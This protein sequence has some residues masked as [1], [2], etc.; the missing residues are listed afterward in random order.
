MFNP[1]QIKD[2]L[3]NKNVYKCSSES[4]TYSK[5]F[6]L[7]AIRRYYDDGY[8]P[9]A[10]FREA[11]FNLDVIGRNRPKECLTRWRNTYNN[12]GEKELTK[13]TRGRPG[14][15]RPKMEFKSDKEKIKYLEAKI[16][17]VDAE[18]DFLAKLRGLKRK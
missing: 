7:W 5:Q 8:S 17:Y 2:L 10:I 16:A 18:N 9:N 4:I 12:K 14:G 3:S 15:K 13:E 1:E 11:G 6:K